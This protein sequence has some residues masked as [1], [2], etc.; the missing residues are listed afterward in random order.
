MPGLHDVRRWLGRNFRRTVEVI[1]LVVSVVAGLAVV[2]S[3]AASGASSFSILSLAAGAVFALVLVG[4]VFLFTTMSRDLRLLRERYTTNDTACVDGRTV[5][6][7]S[8]PQS[9]TDGH[10]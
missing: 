9:P 4:S 2:G 10:V 3:C 7:I 5:Q 1:L 6:D 8:T